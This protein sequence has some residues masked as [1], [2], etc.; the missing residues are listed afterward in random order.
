M[1]RP[2]A[3]RLAEARRLD[4]WPFLSWCFAAG[5]LVADLELLALGPRGGSHHTTWARLHPHDV[6]RARR[7]AGELGWCPE[8]VPRVAVGALALVCLTR[9]V[10]LEEL[11]VADL[12]AVAARIE[13]SPLIPVATRKH[14][15]AEQHSPRMACYQL[16][17]IDTPPEHGNLRRISLTDRVAHIPQPPIRQAVLRYLHTIATTL[18]PKS[19]E[20]RA[21]SPRVFAGWLARA[22]PDIDTLTRLECTHLEEFLIFHAGRVSHGRV[23]SGQPISVRRH[24]RAVQDLRVFFD[25]LAGWGWAERPGRRRR[26]LGTHDFLLVTSDD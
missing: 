12:D 11:T 26:H 21:A 8:Y 6:T 2:V 4:A 20:G 25:D 17:V 10:T 13:A 7:V 15:R 1:A 9:A 22:H 16:G 14:L 24:H 5:A 3:D 18:R 23:R 19:V